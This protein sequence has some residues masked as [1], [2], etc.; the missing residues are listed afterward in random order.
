MK[1]MLLTF[2]PPLLL[3]LFISSKY[4]STMEDRSRMVPNGSQTT[5]AKNA[6]AIKGIQYAVTY[7]LVNQ[8]V[9][10]DSYLRDS[11][12]QFVMVLC[13]YFA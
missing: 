10:M 7:E 12:V 2:L 4:V 6:C 8:H 9:N 1:Y 5:N 3:I 13:F 11:A